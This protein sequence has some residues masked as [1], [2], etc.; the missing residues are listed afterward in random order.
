MRT[1]YG[2][3]YFSGRSPSGLIAPW[4]VSDDA[5]YVLMRSGMG[6]SLTLLN[7]V[8]G[9]ESVVITTSTPDEFP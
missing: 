8:S 1:A 9:V 3:L 5:R 2:G 7:V 4:A 6:R